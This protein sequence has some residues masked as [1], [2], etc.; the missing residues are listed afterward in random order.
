MRALGNLWT[1]G[2]AAWECQ[3]LPHGGRSE[4]PDYTA[5]PARTG[6]RPRP[7]PWCARQPHP[8]LIDPSDTTASHS[9]A[10]ARVAD[11]RADR[12]IYDPTMTIVTTRPR[13]RPAK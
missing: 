8:G 11:R 9:N 2:A 13:K 3:S 10:A 6:Y 4:C 1:A 5:P 7:A 12:Y